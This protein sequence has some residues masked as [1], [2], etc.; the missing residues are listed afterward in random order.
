M[1]LCASIFSSPCL[2]EWVK[3]N[4]MLWSY[5]LGYFFAV[6]V[7]HFPISQ[8]VA[9]MKKSIN[10]QIN[11]NSRGPEYWQPIAIGWVERVLYVTS[12]QL[13][14]PEFIGIWLTL[15]IAA[16]WHRWSRRKDG[17]AIFNIFLIGNAL[18]I[19]YAVTGAKLIEWSSSSEWEFIIGVP[20]SL[21]LA[22]LL[23]WWWLN[24]MRR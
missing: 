21:L 18:S 8:V 3:D 23:F 1:G 13:A 17:R 24:R 16:Q 14:K 19:L 2:F 22:T 4:S 9:Q 20:I 12:I 6:A 7:A 15:K 10:Q 11:R 5:I